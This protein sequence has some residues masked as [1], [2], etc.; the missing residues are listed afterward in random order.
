[1]ERVGRVKVPQVRRELHSTTATAALGQTV[2]R[3]FTAS[4]Q[5]SHFV[6]LIVHDQNNVSS[7]KDFIAHLIQS[8]SYDNQLRWK[9]RA[10][11]TSMWRPCPP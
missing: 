1:M 8:I 10:E 3:H 9:Q 2:S 11:S 7:L 4:I 6:L 5:L